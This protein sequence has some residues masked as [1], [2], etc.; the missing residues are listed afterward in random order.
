MGHSTPFYS[1]VAHGGSDI[2]TE[3]TGWDRD[4]GVDR[5]GRRLHD[6]QQ[7]QGLG[8][9][10]TFRGHKNV[11]ILLYLKNRRKL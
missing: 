5:A 3:V 9:P 4:P 1:C 11:L 2:A 8:V 7:V 6:A 10:I